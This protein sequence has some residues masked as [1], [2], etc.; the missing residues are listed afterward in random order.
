MAAQG[1]APLQGRKSID[2]VANALGLHGK[3]AQGR[4]RAGSRRVRTQARRG[5]ILLG[6]GQAGAV[7]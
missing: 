4:W 6:T 2:P 5:T 7:K 1:P 3:K